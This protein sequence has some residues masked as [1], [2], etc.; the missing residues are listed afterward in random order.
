[1]STTLQ[2]RRPFSEA[3][4]P[5]VDP[6]VETTARQRMADCPY[7]FYFKD[8]IVSHA[9]DVLTLRGRVP[10]FYLKQIVQSLLKNLEGVERIDNLVDVISAV[11]LSSVR[12]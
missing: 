12:P 6:S 2:K 3:S 10:T 7:G 1:M 5:R 11:G 4:D 8:V 9:D